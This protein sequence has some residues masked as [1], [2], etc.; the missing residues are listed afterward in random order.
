[1]IKFPKAVDISSFHKNLKIKTT[2][3]GLPTDVLYC[4]KCVISNQRPNSTIE[5]LNNIDQ[6]KTTIKFD[7]DGV[8]DACNL[9][10]RKKNN[11]DWDKREKDLIKLCNRF[12]KED[13]SYDCI[14]PG[15]GGKDSFYTSHVLKH[16]YKM[17][18]LTV[19]WAPHIY[20]DWGRRNFD[21]W[22]HAGH[23]NYLIS[24]NGKVHRL[25]TRLSMDILF[26]PFQPFIIGQKLV[27]SKLAL[28]LK[29]PL[30]F[31]GENESE[32][33]NPISD[34]E[35]A[36]RSEEYF[37]SDSKDLYLGGVHVDELLNKFSITKNELSPYL[38]LKSENFEKIKIET[39]YLGY[40]LK[41]HPQAC[42]YYSVEN[43]GFEASPER[44][45][46][47]YSKY[48]SIDDKID[49][50]HFYTTGIKFGIGRA[51]HEAAQEIRS[52]DIERDEGVSLVKRYDHEY[53]ERF[54]DE[55]FSYLSIN[56]KEFPDAHKMFEQPIFDEKYFNNLTDNFRSPHIWY[57][58]KKKDSNQVWH[59]RHTLK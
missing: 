38:P 53:P 42:Y 3:Y 48:T 45:V 36:L 33:G 22:I 30:I 41:W 34:T 29:I 19:T 11:I 4:K 56:E 55:L 1:M 47:T 10:E 46:G 14:V 27:A 2:K 57:Y 18:P 15:S 58:E 5:F 25:L 6:N 39:H 28:Q 12:R 26:H 44:T 50:L 13:G 8:C 31:Y 35:T 21:R 20:T 51:S 59:L 43:G 17:N 54:K 32:Y 49:D 24:P 16:K 52:G 37:K 23:D 40:Y 9:S 7:Q